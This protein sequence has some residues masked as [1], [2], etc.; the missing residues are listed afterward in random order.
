[1]YHITTQRTAFMLLGYFKG[2]K[3]ALHAHHGCKLNIHLSILVI[4]HE[5]LTK[6]MS[7]S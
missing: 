4:L 7:N 1:M 6:I 3:A 2:Q 5:S